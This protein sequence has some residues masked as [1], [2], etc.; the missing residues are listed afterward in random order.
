M[1]VSSIVSRIAA[2]AAA[3]ILEF[4]AELT[5]R[6]VDPAAREHQCAGGERHAFGALDHQQLGRAVGTVAHHDQRR[7]G[8]RLV[9]H[10][11]A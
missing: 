5:I 10:G 1:A 9:G 7:G 2:T 4:F 8:D 11:V 3:S 6:R